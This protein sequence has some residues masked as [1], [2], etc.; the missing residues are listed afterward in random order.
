VKHK[1]SRWPLDSLGWQRGSLSLVQANERFITDRVW[2]KR[3]ES[4][5]VHYGACYPPC[6]AWEIWWHELKYFAISTSIY[7]LAFGWWLNETKS[8]EKKN[9]SGDQVHKCCTNFNSFIENM[10]YLTW[11]LIY[12]AP[13]GQKGNHGLFEKVLDLTG[14]YVTSDN[15]VD[16]RRG[17]LNIW[18]IATLIIAHACGDYKFCFGSD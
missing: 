17:R 12:L 6:S 13:L 14:I 5:T 4:L 1:A 2:K 18:P 9:H 7:A 10:V 3:H 11:A 8:M 15:I 16:F